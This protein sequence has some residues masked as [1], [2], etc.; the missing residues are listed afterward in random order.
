MA[1]EA[2]DRA[3][4]VAELRRRVDKV[5]VAMVTT[6]AADRILHARPMLVVAIGDEATLTF[7]THL[8][9]VKVEDVGRDPRTNASFVDER[10]T[11]YVSVGGTASAVHDPARMRELW[12]PSYRA[13]FPGGAEDPDGAIFTVEI[14]RIDYWD[15][16][17]SRMIRLWG[18]VKAL[19]TG[20]VAESGERDTID[21]ARR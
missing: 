9:S 19:A 3:A 17:A 1:S 13:W 11:C 2:A 7:L 16:P 12:N 14:E 21:L 6:I 18:A 15:V 4:A 20:T 8:S 10:G 5:P